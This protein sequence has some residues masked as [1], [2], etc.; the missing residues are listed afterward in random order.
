MLICASINLPA[1]T[2]RA[3]RPVPSRRT[4]RR[5]SSTAPGCRLAG[6]FF[7]ISGGAAGPEGDFYFVDSHWQRILCW[8]CAERQLATV[9]DTP[10]DPVNL[11]VD[12]AGDLI[13][14]SYAGNG[15]VYTL[16]ANGEVRPLKPKQ[17]S[18]LA[19]RDLYLPSSDWH[20][21]QESLG[22]P[23]A[24]FVYHRPTFALPRRGKWTWMDTDARGGWKMDGRLRPR[25]TDH[26]L[27]ILRGMV[28]GFIG[29]MVGKTGWQYFLA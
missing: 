8:R 17:V 11:A 13:V 22:Q 25:T 9:C 12:R 23:A 29:H 28:S 15:V 20:L 1:W 27:Q 26:G 2:F 24:D 4:V 21:N 5:S 10:L 19:G 6:G 18:D 7:N 16:T 14:V 3:A